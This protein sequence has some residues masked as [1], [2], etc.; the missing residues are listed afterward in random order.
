M[1]MDELPEENG[2]QVKEI[3]GKSGQLVRIYTKKPKRG[4]H[5]VRERRDGAYGIRG[6]DMVDDDEVSASEKRILCFIVPES[7]ELPYPLR[8]LPM[9]RGK[10]AMEY[11]I[12]E[13][14]REE[15]FS[16]VYPFE[17]RP[18]LSDELFDIHEEKKFKVK[19][20]K[21]IRQFGRNL[22]ASPYYAKSG[23]MVV[24]WLEDELSM[25]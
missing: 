21:V 17:N 11:V 3:A 22:L 13:E 4:G 12:P 8:E 20:F 25:F 9:W 6:D 19:D 14:A 15:V 24:D 5:V 10:P 2:Y 7:P 16:E 18:S 23:G 1:N